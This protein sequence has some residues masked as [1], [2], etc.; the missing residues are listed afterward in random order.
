MPSRHLESGVGPV[1]EVAVWLESPDGQAIKVNAFLDD[2]SDSTYVRD[3]IIPALGLVANERNLRLSTLTD[4]CVPLKSKKVTLTIKSLDGETQSTIEAWTLQEMCQGLSIPDWNQHKAKWDHLKNITFPKAPGR[5]TIDIL[6]GSDHPELSLALTECYGPIGAPVAKGGPV[7]DV[8]PPCL[9]LRGLLSPE[10]SQRKLYARHALMNK[11]KKCG[12]LTL[13][14]FEIRRLT[15]YCKSGRNLSNDKGGK[16]KAMDRR[17]L[18]G[19]NSVEGR[20]T[21]ST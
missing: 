7:L 18:R 20:I 15:N 12:R 3:D 10:P 14:E 19:R 8:Y 11:C 6:I 1:N 2:E 16:V 5:N 13:S 21:L 4:S 9:Q 17:S